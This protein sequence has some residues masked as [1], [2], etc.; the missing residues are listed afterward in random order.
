MVALDFFNNGEAERYC[1]DL[2]AAGEK[3]GLDQDKLDDWLADLET[4]DR[5]GAFFLA[6]PWVYVLG[7]K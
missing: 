2:I 6:V 1:R 7:R 5:S 3:E 4:L